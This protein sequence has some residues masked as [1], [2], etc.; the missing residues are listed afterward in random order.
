MMPGHTSNHI[1]FN[2]I[3]LHHI[4]FIYHLTSHCASHSALYITLHIAPHLITSDYI[5][6]AHA[7]IH[8]VIMSQD[9]NPEQAN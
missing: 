7:I 6:L 4:D 2:D 1:W 9:S 3:T 5:V 8:A